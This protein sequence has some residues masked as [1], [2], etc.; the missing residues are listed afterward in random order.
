MALRPKLSLP[1]T[2]EMKTPERKSA[3]KTAVNQNIIGNEC[4]LDRA[5]DFFHVSHAAL[6]KRTPDV[7]PPSR[8]LHGSDFWRVIIHL[9]VDS[10]LL[11]F[12]VTFR[13]QNTQI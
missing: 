1:G 13:N 3:I 6:S 8:R 9:G 4:I 5:Y 7:M 10:G 2:P 12:P 11:A